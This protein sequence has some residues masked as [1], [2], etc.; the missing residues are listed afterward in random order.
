[1][2]AEGYTSRGSEQAEPRRGAIAVAIALAASLGTPPAHGLSAE[3]DAPFP[4]SP[5]A[6]EPAFRG[7]T[8]GPI[9]SALHP[10]KGYG[11]AAFQR[12]LDEAKRLGASWVS[13]TPFGRVLDLQPSGVS[14]TFE[15]KYETN[16]KAVLRAIGQ[17]HR[18]GLRVLLVPHLWVESGGWRGEIDPGDDAAWE[19]WS[20]SYAAFLRG[21][22]EVAREGR[23][24]MLAVGVELRSWV[25]TTHAPSF[26][27]LVRE[28]RG[29]YPGPLTYAANWDDAETTVVWGELDVIGVNAFFP[30]ANEPGA[31]PEKLLEGGRDVAK[32]LGA[33]SREWGKPVALTEF[34]YTT[35]PDPAV[36]PWEWPDKM[37]DVAVDEVATKR[38]SRRSSTKRGSPGLSCGA[39]TRIR[40]TSRRRPNGGF[41]RAASSPSSCCVTRL[42]PV[43]RATGRGRSGGR[44]CAMLQRRRGC[45]DE[46][47]FWFW[48][49]GGELG[50][51]D[52]RLR[53]KIAGAPR[54]EVARGVPRGRGLWEQGVVL[55][56]PLYGRLYGLV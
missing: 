29:V 26:A 23:V 11:S 7:I 56:R 2:R 25:T 53:R 51:R 19:R 30:L 21:W 47:H 12:T 40:T 4:R 28:I 16:R 17:A 20:A 34:G 32:R 6:S 42:P 48:V 27:A 5:F 1:L 50:F 38:S 54:R 49:F 24:D 46:R 39:S 33:L 9:E 14:W 37:T 55:V 45:S 18:K 52:P 10:E 8:I 22:A 43:G 3:S 35:R 15:E 41:H 36:R 13:L 31:G 44:S